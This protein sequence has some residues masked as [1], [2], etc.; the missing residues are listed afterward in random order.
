MAG[1]C[2]VAAQGIT[3]GSLGVALFTI[4]TVA[5]QTGMS[6]AV[7]HWGLGP[8][9][10]LPVTALRILAAVLATVAVGVAAWGTGAESDAATTT[11]F[12]VSLA[13]FAGAAVA[14]QAAFNGRVSV[15]TGQ[16]T[17][18]A[19][20][21]F[22]VGLALLLVVWAIQRALRGDVFEALPD[23][24]EQPWLYTGGV[25]GLIFVVGSAW[26][27]R[28]LGVLLLTL[29]VISG[30]LIGAV[31]VDLVVPTSGGS[32]TVNL[33]VGVLLTFVAVALASARTR[34]TSSWQD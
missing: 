11:L 17:V 12:F 28:A 16:P 1:A 20:V 31:V 9:G 14:F 13:L 30:S 33:A 19:F 15:G 25:M 3:V 21:N 32:F 27:V 7:D 5:G 6:L 2:Y 10:I 29:L 34:A 4:A 8:S 26:S 23:P 24:T 18:A 22:C